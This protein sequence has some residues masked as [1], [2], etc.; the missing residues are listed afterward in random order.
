MDPEQQRLDEDRDRKKN[1]KRW[2]PYVSER[3][4]GTV[5]EDYSASVT[6]SYFYSLSKQG[7][8]WNFISHDKSRSQAY[9]WGEDGIMVRNSCTQSNIKGYY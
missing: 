3:E 7:D 1:W 5:R 2:G 6:Y 4:W 9:R 8:A